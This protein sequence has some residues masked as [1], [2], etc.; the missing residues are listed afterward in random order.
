MGEATGYGE[1]RRGWPVVLAAFLGI[2]LGLSPLPFY[3]MGVFAP[4]FAREFGW[5]TA[6]IMAGLTVTT[7]SVLGSAPLVGL[8]P[9]RF[10]VRRVALT[11]LVLFSL[12]F[13]SL[14]LSSGSLVQFDVTWAAVAVLGAGTLPMTWTPAVNDLFEVRKGLALGVS[15]M[16]TGLFGFLA[17]PT[18]A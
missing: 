10:G 18:L 17:K 12:A 6:Q 1:F 16:G 3:T 4:H 13:M 7:V 8:L 11:S 15:L 5:S 14:A 2:G 9:V